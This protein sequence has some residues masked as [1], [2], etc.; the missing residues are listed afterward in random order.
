MQTLMTAETLPKD[1]SGCEALARKHDE[2]NLEV[3]YSSISPLS[4]SLYY[5]NFIFLQMQG[6][7]THVDSFTTNGRHM[8]QKGHVLSQEI[9]TKVETL[10]RA[11]S[12]L[13]E[14]WK[15]RHELYTA[16]MDLQQ[17]KLNAQELEQWLIERE[18]LLGLK[19]YLDVFNILYVQEKTGRRSIPLTQ[20]KPI[21]ETTMTSW[22]LLNLKP[23]DV[24]TLRD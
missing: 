19:R 17:W 4:F 9:I 2:Y 11:W 23:N 22:S 20:L 16:N 8:I 3:Y 13:C 18:R 12:V 24:N 5:I 14:V 1:V 6:R 10:E 21:S 15:D 7:K